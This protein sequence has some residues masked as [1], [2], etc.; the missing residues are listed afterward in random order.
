MHA[1]QAVTLHRPLPSDATLIGRTKVV[2]IQDKGA[3]RGALVFAERRI[4]DVATGD[5]VCTVEQT[6]YCRGDGGCGGDDAPPRA[7][8]V[9][10]ERAPEHR[11]E[12]VIP[13]DAAL[14]YRLNGDLNPL[15]VDPEV[16]EHA[17]FERPILHGLCTFGLAGVA[18]LEAVRGWDPAGFSFMTA[19]FTAPVFPGDRLVTEI[20]QDGPT[21]SFRASLPDR[22]AVAL[23]RGRIDLTES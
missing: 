6:A 22:G 14:L 10:P 1:E 2:G 11:H 23:D 13:L 15:H 5:L 17:G 20:W 7:P 18:V 21:I 4:S 16:A 8:H 9:I 19:R 12:T 3:S